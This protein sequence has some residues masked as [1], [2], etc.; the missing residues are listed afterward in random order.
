MQSR[1]TGNE[2]Q[3]KYGA[4]IN[5]TAA[6]NGV[7]DCA[8]GSDESVCSSSGLQIK[9]GPSVIPLIR[10]ELYSGFQ[11]HD[12]TKANYY[13]PHPLK[14]T[15]YISH[16]HYVNLEHYTRWCNENNFSGDGIC[17]IPYSNDRTIVITD[18]ESGSV[19][20]IIPGSKAPK[21]SKMKITCKQDYVLPN[22]TK[23]Q[24]SVCLPKQ[25]WHPPVEPCIS[26]YSLTL[27]LVINKFCFLSSSSS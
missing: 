13:I 14:F 5:K 18:D 11:L 19:I 4:C 16:S 6:C 21:F 12:I 22:R 25:K 27:T 3:C 2:F 10:W 20:N 23:V 26:K 1:C 24:V 9:T 17:D 15:L 7:R 8:D